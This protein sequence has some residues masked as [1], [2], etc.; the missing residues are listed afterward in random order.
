MLI[1]LFALAHLPIFRKPLPLQSPR[2]GKGTATTKHATT[3]TITTTEA[4]TNTNA[5]LTA[6]TSNSNLQTVPTT[7]GTE[8]TTIL[9][10][11]CLNMSSSTEQDQA[12]TAGFIVVANGNQSDTKKIEVMYVLA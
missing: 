4:I 5:H 6:L 8:R 7:A 10:G 11:T 3:T 2:C 1:A 9:I 12:A